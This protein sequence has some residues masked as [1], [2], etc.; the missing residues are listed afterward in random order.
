MSRRIIA[1]GLVLFGAGSAAVADDVEVLNAVFSLQAEGVWRV[2]ATLEHADTGWEHYADAWRVVDADGN[3]F[4]T[5]TLLHPHE[6]E[7]PF[8]RGL[9][10]VVIPPAISMVY[11][12]AHDKVHG[13]A[14]KKLAVDLT[15]EQGPGYEVKR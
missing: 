15:L 8:T 13:W 14:E 1:L 6:Q 7:Q 9:S 5:R 2:S 12:E 3:V 11:V 4:G 10:D